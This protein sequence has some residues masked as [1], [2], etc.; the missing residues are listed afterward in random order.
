LLDKITI[1]EIKSERINE[2]GKLAHVRAELAAL[3]RARVEAV[4]KS[5]ELARLT[6]R[7]KAVNE[8][9]WQVE[10]AIRECEGRQDFG[11]R[12]V[13]LARSV[14]RRNDERAALKRQINK[15]LGAPYQEQKAYTVYA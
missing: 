4:A 9:L 11:E 8:V 13:E 15:L 14:Y 7:L 5:D 3:D 6:A 1:L 2:P 10:D 12:F